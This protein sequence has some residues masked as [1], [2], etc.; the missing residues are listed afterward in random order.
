M[1]RKPYYFRRLFGIRDRY[2]FKILYD[3]G[4]QRKFVAYPLMIKIDR[5]FRWMGRD[6]ITV[7]GGAKDPF[8]S[9]YLKPMG[10]SAVVGV[11]GGIIF[12]AKR[13]K[14]LILF[15]PLL[16]YSAGSFGVGDAL[17]RYLHPIDWLG[18]I[19]AGVAL[20]LV[21]SMIVHLHY[22][23]FTAFRF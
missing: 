5:Y 16:L 22:R 1:D 6:Q 11:I 9:L 19:F 15:I 4:R 8:P 13:L 18:V 17:S 21:I 12:S 7:S 2:S 10:F 3:N 14:I 23:L 20:D